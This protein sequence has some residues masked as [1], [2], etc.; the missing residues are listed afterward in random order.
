MKHTTIWAY[1]ARGE[2]SD[3]PVVFLHGFMG[4]GADWLPIAENYANRFFCLMPDLPGHGHNIHLPLAQPLDFDSVVNGLNLLLEQLNLDRI[5]LVGYSLGGRIALYAA[6]KF[7]QKIRSL[8]LESCHAG[9]VDEQARRERAEADDRQAEA[10]LTHGLETFVERWYEMDLFRTLQSQ[11]QLLAEIKEKRKK[12]D[13]RWVAKTLKELSPGRQPPLWT[14]LGALPM[15]VL[16]IAGTL[17][18]KYTELAAKMSQ[19]IPRAR[20][21][22][23]P[24]VG[25]NVHL[26]YPKQFGKV[27]S[28][29]LQE[30]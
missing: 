27:I 8:V 23:I 9:I 24:G 26:E 12:N 18:T 15:P 5:S 2:P 16:L 11:S 1:H 21:E 19:Q 20:L 10:V 6:L 25:H 22:I 14:K 7:P 13:P 3:P 4:A 28:V 17:D 29:F 30:K